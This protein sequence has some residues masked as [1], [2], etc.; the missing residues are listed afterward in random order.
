MSRQAEAATK[1]LASYRAATG[2]RP[3]ERARALRKLQVRLSSG[4]TPQASCDL[5][6]PELSQPES[7]LLLQRRA[8]HHGGRPGARSADLDP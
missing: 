6:P 1:L 3:E 8:R 5:P 2:L 4:A 7:A